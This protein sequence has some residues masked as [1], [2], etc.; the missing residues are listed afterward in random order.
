M[1][2]LENGID[3]IETLRGKLEIRQMQSRANLR[4]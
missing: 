3:T 2:L 1:V 4:K